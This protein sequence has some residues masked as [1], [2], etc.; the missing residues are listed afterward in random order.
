MEN[1]ALERFRTL[2]QDD[3]GNPIEWCNDEMDEQFRKD[4]ND[5]YFTYITSEPVK[6]VIKLSDRYN[7]IPKVLQKQLRPLESVQFDKHLQ[8]VTLQRK[9]NG[10]LLRMNN[11]NFQ[12]ATAKSVLPDNDPCFQTDF[13]FLYLYLQWSN[14]I[15]NNKN[16]RNNINN[17]NVSN[18]HIVPTCRTPLQTDHSSHEPDE[19]T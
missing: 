9:N 7:D 15:N 17:T 19:K 1:S 10:R 3:K 16:I 8:K 14:S 2:G 12:N 4:Y 5:G 11:T 13:H 6:D 18:T